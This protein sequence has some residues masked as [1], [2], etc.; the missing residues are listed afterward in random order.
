MTQEKSVNVIGIVMKLILELFQN[1]VELV[2]F[3][4]VISDHFQ[5]F[6][7]NFIEE[8]KS[9]RNFTNKNFFLVI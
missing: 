7:K 6:C 5:S 4:S 1:L 9:K 3:L 8:E 2:Y